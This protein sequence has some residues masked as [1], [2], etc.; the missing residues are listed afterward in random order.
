MDRSRTWRT[1]D[2]AATVAQTADEVWAAVVAAGSGGHWYVDAFPWKF[3][4][5]LDRLTGGEGRRWPVP[6]KGRLEAGDHAGFWEVLEVDDVR[7]RLVLEAKVRAPGRVR[8]TTDVV[9]A[10]TGA[11]I[12]QTTRLD[13]AGVPGWAYL[14][15]DLPAREVVSEWS[16]LHLLTEVRLRSGASGRA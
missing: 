15:V 7:R 11:R 4:G 1:T 10:T 8:I 3:R 2:R 14:L 16:L 13:P 5:G 6:S 12:V 9:P